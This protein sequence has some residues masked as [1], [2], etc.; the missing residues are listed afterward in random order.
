MHLRCAEAVDEAVL[1]QRYD[2]DAREYAGRALSRVAALRSQIRG[3]MRGFRRYG[4]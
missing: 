2:A 4:Q 1:E 3:F